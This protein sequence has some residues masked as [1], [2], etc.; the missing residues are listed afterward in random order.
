MGRRQ[1]GARRFRGIV[2]REH[3]G[4]GGES[5]RLCRGMHAFTTD[6][7]YTIATIV[8]LMRRLCIRSL[9]DDLHYD[10]GPLRTII[11]IYYRYTELFIVTVRVCKLEIASRRRQDAFRASSML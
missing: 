1:S 6:D 11:T 10:Y 5:K 2:S 4:R 9:Q 8:T 7:R 3:E